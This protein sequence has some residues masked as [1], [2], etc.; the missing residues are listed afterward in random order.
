[1]SG[2]THKLMLYKKIIIK[3]KSE[4]KDNIKRRDDL[5]LAQ[6]LYEDSDG[7]VVRRHFLDVGAIVTPTVVKA[8]LEGAGQNNTIREHPHKKNSQWREDHTHTVPCTCL[9]L[10]TAS[11]R[12]CRNPASAELKQEVTKL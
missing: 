7:P 4:N 3:S 9:P 12:R 11:Q 6:F 10:Y 8:N 2:Q 5:L 1:M